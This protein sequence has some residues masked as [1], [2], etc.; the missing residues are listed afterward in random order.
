MQVQTKHHAGDRNILRPLDLEVARYAATAWIPHEAWTVANH[1]SLGEVNQS[2]PSRPPVPRHAHGSPKNT[3]QHREVAKHAHLAIPG[4]VSHS[5]HA[6]LYLGI[7][8]DGP[9]K[10][11]VVY[12]QR[13]LWSPPHVCPECRS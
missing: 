11:A 7:A 4:L 6:G 10:D 13:T 9:V 3:L 12:V 2:L 8:V 1:A 5:E